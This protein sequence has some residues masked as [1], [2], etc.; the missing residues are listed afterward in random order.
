[1]GRFADRPLR[2]DQPVELRL[3]VH[4]GTVRGLV[5]HAGDEWPEMGTARI[6]ADATFLA[7][8]SGVKTGPDEV[9]IARLREIT[10]K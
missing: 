8:V 7:G 10:D 3:E 9:V 4:A 6:D 1:M 5:R 2:P